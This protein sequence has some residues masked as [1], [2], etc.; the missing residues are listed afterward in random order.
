MFCVWTIIG[1]DLNEV[2]SQTETTQTSFVPHTNKSLNVIS[3]NGASGAVLLT[4]ISYRLFKP[5]KLLLPVDLSS[6]ALR[7]DGVLS[8]WL[9]FLFHFFFHFFSQGFSDLKIC[10]APEVQQKTH[11]TMI[12]C[13]HSIQITW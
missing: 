4:L 12:P 3:N 13:I 7:D 10:K 11:D 6:D 5:F 9:F 1:A 8:C 2:A